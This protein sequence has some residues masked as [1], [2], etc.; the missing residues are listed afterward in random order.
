L[1]TACERTTAAIET[2]RRGAGRGNK[3]SADQGSFSVDEAE[4]HTGI[5]HQQVS[6]WRRRLREPEKYRAMLFGAVYH[7]AMAEANSTTA[8]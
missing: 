3:K 4:A 1:A 2:A 6:K 7:T 5:T 8:A